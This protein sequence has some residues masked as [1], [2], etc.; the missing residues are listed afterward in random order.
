MSSVWTAISDLAAQ[1]LTSPLINIL[2]LFVPILVVEAICQKTHYEHKKGILEYLML[3]DY[4][5]PICLCWLAL[6]AAWYNLEEET[7]TSV[8]KS[9]I[10]GWPVAMSVRDF[11]D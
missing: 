2:I 11:L 8:K 6:L 7:P 10:L 4:K 5:I 9:P 3:H 1:P